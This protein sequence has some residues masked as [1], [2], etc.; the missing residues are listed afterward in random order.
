MKTIVL[1]ERLS[2]KQQKILNGRFTEY[3]IHLAKEITAE[4][5][6]C[7]GG[8]NA[9]FVWPTP[10]SF[11]LLFGEIAYWAG[12]GLAGDHLDA[13]LKGADVSI[14]ILDNERLR[15]FPEIEIE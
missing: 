12:Y 7:S 9:V 1:C 6:S 10:K 14:W 13:C 3:E 4:A 15:A 2:P 5:I 8:C 11:P